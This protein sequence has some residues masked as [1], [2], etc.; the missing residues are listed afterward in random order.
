MNQENYLYRAPL[1]DVRQHVRGY[2]LGWQCS[3]RSAPAPSKDAF[4]R[5]VGLIACAHEKPTS[6]PFFIET[7]TAAL[8][9]N[10]LHGLIPENIVLIFD[11]K[12]LSNAGALSRVMSLNAHGFGLAMR[13]PDRAALASDDGLL[14]LMTHLQAEFGHPDLA[15]MAS[16]TKQA[17]HSLCV[18]VNNVSDWQEFEACAALGVM[19]FFGNLCALPRQQRQST[20]L[21]PHAAI[22]VQL[23]QMVHD[24]VDVR[25][26][27]KLL[28][29]D[30]LLSYK[31]IRHIN[32]AS[33]GIQSEIK[34]LR[35]AVTML[36]YAPL[37]RW[38][39]L[40]LL[41]NAD[42]VQASPAL[43]QAALVRGRFVELLGQKMLSRQE[44][45]YLFVVGLF[46][47]LEPLLGIPIEQVLDEV[48]LP[49]AIVQALL[50]RQGIY[51]PFLALAQ[52]CESQD[53]NAFHIAESLCMTSAHVNQSH[54]AALVWA[55]NLEFGV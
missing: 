51:G 23:M 32:S 53:G 12:D 16:L 31:L 41:V 26:M 45:G 13:D 35:H 38:L 43:L 3:D 6:R 14:S 55:E 40:F 21:N 19:S 20:Q 44:A 1:L 37:Y 2:R 34:S 50:Y 52:A 39:A 30:A 46:S 9:V 28:K 17:E 11:Q 27:E 33:F 54:L 24:N 48:S 29:R 47:L 5:L 36:G 4:A 10:T 18:L 25:E 42:Q 15:E 8:P 7:G 22:V 49:Q